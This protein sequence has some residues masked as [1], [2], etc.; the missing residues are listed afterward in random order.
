MVPDSTKGTADND[1]SKVPAFNTTPVFGFTVPLPLVTVTLIN[2]FW[3]CT[4]YDGVAKPL[5]VGEVREE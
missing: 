5:P 2:T 4:A 3:L 1:P